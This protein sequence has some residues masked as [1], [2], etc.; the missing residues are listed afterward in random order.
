M[1]LIS[2]ILYQNGKVNTVEQHTS[3]YKRRES[4]ILTKQETCW[5]STREHNSSKTAE[6]SILT[7]RWQKK[8]SFSPYPVTEHRKEW[9]VG[10]G[11]L[12]CSTFLFIFVFPGFGCE[13]SDWVYTWMFSSL[14]QMLRN[15]IILLFLL[16]Y[17]FCFY[18]FILLLWFFSQHCVILSDLS[19]IWWLDHYYVVLIILLT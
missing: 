16:V 15:Q 6:H 19:I 12:P 10:D 4:H 3:K 11:R 14:Y 17:Y 8:E 2:L 7:V 9:L 18:Y 1:S 13:I 5:K